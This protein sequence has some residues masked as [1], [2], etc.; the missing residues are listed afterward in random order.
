MPGR[1]ELDWLCED[2]LQFSAMDFLLH[3]SLGYTPQRLDTTKVVKSQCQPESEF[4]K[5]LLLVLL[6][7]SNPNKKYSF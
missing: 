2:A 1:E 4:D 7:K 6:Q 5:P 3:F